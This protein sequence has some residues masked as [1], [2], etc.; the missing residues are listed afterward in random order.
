[1]GYCFSKELLAKLKQCD[2]VKYF[3]S[4]FPKIP[5]HKSG[6]YWIARCP[7]PD[8]HDETPSFRIHYDS[9]NGWYSWMCFACHAGKKG[10]LTQNGKI[11]RGSDAIAFV[12]WLSDYNGSPHILSFQE[13]VIELLQFFNLPVPEEKKRIVTK[14]ERMNEILSE[15]FQQGFHGSEAESY[16]LNRGL[17]EET[18][19]RFH[20]GTDGERLAIP[21]INERGQ[22]QGMIYRHLHG[23][24]PKYYHSS[25]H[26]GFIKSTYLFGTEYLD[27]SDKNVFITE[28]CFDVM[29]ASQYGVKNVLAC[30]G[31]AFTEGHID[32]LKH[33]GIETV[34]LVFDGDNA[35]VA[36][37]HRAIELLNGSGLSCKVVQLPTGMDLYDLALENKDRTMEFINLYTMPDYRY[38]FNAAA[39]AYKMAKYALQEKNMDAIMK[40]A[41]T[42]TKQEDY[43]RFKQYV[44][45]EFDIRLEQEYVRETKT[46]L[47]NPIPA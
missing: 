4:R 45:D 11:I 21:L 15:A 2:L 26:E 34:S 24:E 35:G 12:I 6:E 30:L 31:T 27:S 18:L 22:I 38:E 8:H 37:T 14:Q 23:E 20:V 43:K 44:F 28:G 42:F 9:K 33:C 46:D 16:A 3:K 5:I 36:A 7:H 25:A 10:E 29:L 13:A 32:L 41:N 19:K 1:M 17:S 47:E 39:M 40:K